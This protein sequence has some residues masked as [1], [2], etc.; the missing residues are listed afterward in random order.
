MGARTFGAFVAGFAAGVLILGGALWG[1]GSVK[2]SVMPP[3]LRAKMSATLPVPAE[4]LNANAQLP[5]PPVPPPEE[6][7]APP[8]AAAPPAPTFAPAKTT[9]SAERAAGEPGSISPAPAL[10]LSMPVAGI[11]PATLTESFHD[12]RDGHQHEA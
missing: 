9:G 12:M 8:A 2:S 5:G 7:P 6:V 3:W 4:N 1:T 10:H 11:D